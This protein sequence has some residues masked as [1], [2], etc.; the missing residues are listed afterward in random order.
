MQAAMEM[1][2]K[3]LIDR[4]IVCCLNCTEGSPNGIL[5]EACPYGDH[6]ERCP[7]LQDAMRF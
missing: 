5:M 4:H 7:R 2:F 6:S 1:I 3:N